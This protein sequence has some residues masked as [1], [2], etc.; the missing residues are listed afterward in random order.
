MG[1]NK[2]MRNPDLSKLL[3]TMVE[4]KIVL[5]AYIEEIEQATIELEKL[6]KIYSILDAGIE[7][8]SSISNF[9]ESIRKVLNGK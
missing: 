2:K 9:V 6:E 3:R 1:V 4:N 8:G 7:E 5:S